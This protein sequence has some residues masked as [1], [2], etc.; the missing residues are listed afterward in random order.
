MSTRDVGFLPGMLEE[1][2]EMYEIV[3][4]QNKLTRK[5][6]FT[7]RKVMGKLKP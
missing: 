2:I 1:K 4:N 3:N 6:K 5:I 7:I